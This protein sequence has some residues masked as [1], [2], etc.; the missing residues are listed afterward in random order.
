M[1]DDEEEVQVHHFGKERTFSKGKSPHFMFPSQAEAWHA[2]NKIKHDDD[3]VIH[4]TGG[5]E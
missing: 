2:N 4:E 3:S 5:G 1:S